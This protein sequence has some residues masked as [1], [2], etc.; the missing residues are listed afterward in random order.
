MH[1][2]SFHFGS[3]F[4]LVLKLILLLGQSLKLENRFYFS[5]CRQ[6]TNRK[7]IR[8]RRN[9]LFTD[10]TNKKKYLAFSKCHITFKLIKKMPAHKIL[11]KSI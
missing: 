1:F 2:W 3:F 6:P 7:Y 5:P 10:V 9:T 4:D 11:K 8:G